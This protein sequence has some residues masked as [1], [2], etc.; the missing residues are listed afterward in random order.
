MPTNCATGRPAPA[1]LPRSGKPLAVGVMAGL[2]A[3]AAHAETIDCWFSMTGNPQKHFAQ[4][5]WTG[6]PPSSVS[7]NTG[8]R[9]PSQTPKIAF[10]AP[11][12]SAGHIR[13]CHTY[14]DDQATLCF[15]IDRQTGELE[16]WNDRYQDIS[17]AGAC[18]KASEI[19]A[20]F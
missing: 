11:L 4:F 19:R 2:M 9:Y 7:D 18:V 1:A 3:F 17:A 5:S 12:F 20:Q 16:L 8:A 6:S 14:K 13:L 10:Q 15:I